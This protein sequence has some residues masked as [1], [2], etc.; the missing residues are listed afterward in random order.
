MKRNVDRLC[1]FGDSD[2]GKGSRRDHF[3]CIVFFDLDGTL[4]PLG[5]PIPGHVVDRLRELQN[6]AATISLC[7]GKPVYYLTGLA[8]QTGLDNLIL[9]GENGLSI[10]VGVDL[11]PRQQFRMPLP[12]GCGPTLERVR[13]LA[14][15]QFVGRVWEQTNE[16]AVSFIF[17]AGTLNQEFRDFVEQHVDWMKA[18]NV[19]AVEQKDAFDFLPLGVDKGN[20]V[21]TV[22][23]IWGLKKQD[24]LAVGDSYN[25]YPMFDACGDS[26][27]I[28]LP[29]PHRAKRQADDIEQ[30]LELVERFVFSRRQGEP[31]N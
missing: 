16:V 4:A 17:P 13:E 9:I 22:L 7:S 23:E 21:R 5:K 10:Q 29:D 24:A 30:A 20:A 31:A 26:I 19:V 2:V 15:G 6:Q 3:M 1:G 18:G 14:R 11:P 8:R 28:D 27:G 25:D 12:D